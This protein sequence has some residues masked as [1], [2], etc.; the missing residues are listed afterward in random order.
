MKLIALIA[1]A[2]ILDCVHLLEILEH[3][4][5]TEIAALYKEALQLMPP[6]AEEA[7]ATLHYNRA[8]SLEHLSEPGLGIGY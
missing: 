1:Y 8:L 4:L 2:A 7:R 3:P 6:E 5:Y